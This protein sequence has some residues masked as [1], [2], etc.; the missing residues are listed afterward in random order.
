MSNAIYIPPLLF[1]PHHSTSFVPPSSNHNENSV[2]THAAKEF[3][4]T[5]DWNRKEYVILK[6]L[7]RYISYYN[8]ELSPQ[9]V[10]EM[11]LESFLHH[12]KAFHTNFNAKQSITLQDLDNENSFYRLTF[13][14]ISYSL[15]IRR[16]IQNHRIVYI[17][18][19]KYR[20]SW[21][22]LV[23]LKVKHPFQHF[24]SPVTNIKPKKIQTAYETA[25]DHLQFVSHRRDNTI[26]KI[27]EISASPS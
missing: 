26:T 12:Q 21:L 10:T 4:N 17:P 22:E 16:S 15:N 7:F 3:F 1:A 25:R 24:V 11:F 19:S 27:R 23:L 6:D 20:E 5:L 2:T 9:L 14:D 8:L 18:H 13:E